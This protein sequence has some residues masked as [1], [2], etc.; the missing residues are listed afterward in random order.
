VIDCEPDAN[1]SSQRITLSSGSAI[2]AIPDDLGSSTT[3]TRGRC[4]GGIGVELLVDPRPS[5]RSTA[6]A[7]AALACPASPRATFPAPG[8]G[9]HDCRWYADGAS[10]CSV[11]ART[12]R[13]PYRRLGLA[14]AL[15]SSGTHDGQAPAALGSESDRLRRW[16]P[17]SDAAQS[18]VVG[19]PMVAARP[20]QHH[21]RHHL[22]A[23]S[24]AIHPQQRGAPGEQVTAITAWPFARPP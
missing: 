8:L 20:R 7:T 14:E 17:G 3:I 9:N 6:L 24:D 10:R 15:R 1:F 16:A 5:R 19:D 22:P 23:A 18:E 21:A 2:F 4:G 12:C 13:K 11:A